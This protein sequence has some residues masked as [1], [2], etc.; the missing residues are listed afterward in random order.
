MVETRTVDLLSEEDSASSL[1]I[2]NESEVQRSY[3]TDRRSALQVQATLVTAI[4]GKLSPGGAP[5]SLIVTDF[6]FVPQKPRRFKSVLIN[7]TFESRDPNS[8]GPEVFA[9]A[10]SGYSSIRPTQDIV[11]LKRSGKLESL[12]LV[13]PV[14]TFAPEKDAVVS[15]SGSLWEASESSAEQTILSGTIRLERRD[16]GS[17]NTARWVL[18]ENDAKKSGISTFLRTAILLKRDPKKPD[19]TF[20]ATIEI[21]ADVDFASR[22]RG[23]FDRVLGTGRDDPVIFNPNEVSNTVFVIDKDNLGSIKLGDVSAA[24]T[25]EIPEG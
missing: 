5:A 16:F 13:N 22:L 20:Q 10:P 1:R 23:I 2:R 19:E 8:D 18:M 3:I 15:A 7:Y 17:M 4:H 21:Q 14:E 6:S 24:V 9:I 12:K 25:A 11:K